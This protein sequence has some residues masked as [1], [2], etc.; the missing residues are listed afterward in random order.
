M[1]ASLSEINLEL[2]EDTIVCTGREAYLYT[3]NE[4][5]EYFWSNDSATQGIYTDV[6]GIYSVTVT[7]EYSCTAE[8]SVSIN[9]F[10]ALLY[11]SN[12]LDMTDS[13]NPDG[14]AE[15][16]ID[17]GSEPVEILWS[18]DST[19][20][21]ISGMESGVYYYTLIDA[22]ECEYS[23]SVTIGDISGIDSEI[24][25]NRIKLFPNPVSELLNIS[26]DLENQ[27]K[28][29]LLYSSGRVIIDD[30]FKNRD[31]VID[32]SDLSSGVYFVEITN[33]GKRKV[34]KIFKQ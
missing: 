21:S 20:F 24:S 30:K 34:F 33:S 4:F 17:S 16:I 11:S 8:G 27:T 6:P 18:C 10:N 9:N 7:D 2:C 3:L 1:N 22:N 19:S 31:I 12:V 28:L 26:C 25:D 14:F 5:A 15:V 13:D 29:K 23:D 32:V